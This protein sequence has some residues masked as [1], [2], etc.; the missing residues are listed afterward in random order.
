MGL[1]FNLQ[2]QGKPCNEDVWLIL[3]HTFTHWVT[4]TNFM[5]LLPFPR[6]RIY[7]GT[8]SG[9]FGIALSPHYFAEGIDG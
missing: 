5:R 8:I 4:I 7:L 6:S 2:C 1:S 9:W 3:H